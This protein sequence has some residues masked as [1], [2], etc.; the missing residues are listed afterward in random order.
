MKNIFNYIKEYGSYTFEEKEFNDIDNVIFS[1][2]SYVNFNVDILTNKNMF[3]IETIGNQYF[4]NHS[5][6]DI[7]DNILA[8]R[9]G[10]KV[11]E[12]IK[13][14]LRYKSL[15]IYNYVYI[16]D[17]D[18]QFSAMCIKIKKNLIYVSFEGTDQLISGWKEDFQMSYE[19]PV[20]SQKMAIEYLN[21]NI[22]FTDKKVIVGGH[23]K[24][25]NLAMVATMYAKVWVQRKIIKVYNNDGP[26]LRQ[27]QIDTWRYR[28]MSKRLTY[29][30]PNYS[31]VGLLLR[32]SNNYI[33]I[34]SSEIGILAHDFVTWKIEKD[35]F[36]ETDLSTISK[37]LDEVITKWLD[38]Y[39]DIQ[40]QH[41]VEALFDVC[42]R[43]DIKNLL[44]IKKDKFNIVKIMH[45]TKH[46]DNET[47][48]M[49]RSFFDFLLKY[50]ISDIKE[51]ITEYN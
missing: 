16:G 38:N 50:C 22:K 9:H 21:K 1:A 37:T 34:E 6:K 39:N 36:I 49:V 48:Q 31:L 13:D 25:G 17:T 3:T 41:F 14:T 27:R 28:F 46:L 29:I 18:K 8:V 32:H 5:K 40:R 42:D 20:P 12:H 10:I 45:E 15:L 33:V 19:F 7:S 4:K 23:S 43:L 26:G 30:I 35:K 47:K 11:L 2:L 24:G 51:K 44:E